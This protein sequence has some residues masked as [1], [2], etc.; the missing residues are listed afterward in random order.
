MIVIL[1]IILPNFG[2]GTRLKKSESKPLSKYFIFKYSN[3]LNKEMLNLPKS[4]E[5]K[6]LSCN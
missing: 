6:S 2:F 3:I 4:E 1:H 5:S